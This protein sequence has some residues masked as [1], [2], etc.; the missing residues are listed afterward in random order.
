MN[1]IRHDDDGFLLPKQNQQDIEK[2][3]ENTEELLKRHKNLAIKRVRTAASVGCVNAHAPKRQLRQSEN[4]RPTPV[5]K[6]EQFDRAA[7]FRQSKLQTELLETIAQNSKQSRGGIMR[8]LGFGAGM[9]SGLAKLPMNLAKGMLGATRG[10]NGRFLP[11]GTAEKSGV[12]VKLGKA[13]KFLKGIAKGGLLGALFGLFS[14]VGVEESDMT[15]AEKNKA[16]AKNMMI[17][18]G[19]IGGAMA[20]AAI[21][22]VVPVVGTIVGGILGGFG[23]AALMEYWVDWL[24]NR[25]PDNFSNRMFDGWKGFVGSI[26]EAWRAFTHFAAD[27]WTSFSGKL[28]EMAS[29][30]WLAFMPQSVQSFFASVSGFA[31]SAWEKF[32]V[33]ADSFWEN[34]KGVAKVA[35]DNV[36]KPL[37]DFSS[38]LIQQS[39]DAWNQSSVGQ[40]VNSVVQ[41]GVE[42]AK[43]V[44]NNIKDWAIGREVHVKGGRAAT[45]Q[46]EQKLLGELQSAKLVKSNEAIRGGK[47][48]AGTYAAALD[49]RS[50]MGGDLKYFSAFNDEYHKRKSPNS[51]HTKGL[52]L[53]IVNKSGSNKAAREQS[54]RICEQLTAMGFKG[55]LATRENGKNVNIGSGSDFL[56][57]D[58]YNRPS[59]KSSG[60]HIHFNW[61]NQKAANRYFAMTRGGAEVIVDTRVERAANTVQKGASFFAD[62]V[63]GGVAA[64][65][66]MVSHNESRGNY[67]AYNQGTIGNKTIAADRKYDF[68]KMTLNDYLAHTKMGFGKGRIFAWGKYQMIPSTTR[69]AMKSMGLSGKELM[70]PELQERMF[71][72]YLVKEKAGRGKKDND[73]PLYRYIIG[74]HNNRTEAINASAKEWASIGVAGKVLRGQR[75]ISHGRSYYSGQGGNK[76][77]T[78]PEQAGNAIDSLRGEVDALAKEKGISKSQAYSILMSEQA[79]VLSTVSAAAPAKPIQVQ[80][81][82]LPK[83]AVPVVPPKP[84]VPSPVAVHAAPSKPQKVNHTNVFSSANS[85]GAIAHKP[86]SR[87]VGHKQ[88]AHMASGGI[89]DNQA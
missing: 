11:K 34:V 30:L 35:F 63:T 41:S 77:H 64:F 2:I 17:G 9:L 79:T 31:K 80:A 3:L 61:G 69:D 59:A 15:R 87:T 53:D 54:K 21:G 50:A 72:E 48:N 19:G 33:G 56:I 36:I 67:N 43:D 66:K 78:S 76:A 75:I 37:S 49:F 85:V 82:A 23:G 39:A 46:D 28:T 38:N 32:S 20:G 47:A 71:A 81:A 18:A 57:Q 52:A 51:K 58:E 24:D 73:S 42:T 70:T 65:K 14:G 26:R 88:I 84:T 8:L 45:A 29:S 27:T 10:S 44:G 86:V 16:H 62:K 74:E 7:Q 60:G 25:I 13:G 89:M 12:L 55:K 22:S 6:R 68:S 1:E 5:Q 4:T 40:A 83:V